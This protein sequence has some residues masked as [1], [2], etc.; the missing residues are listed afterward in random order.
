MRNISRLVL[1]CVVLFATGCLTPIHQ[2]NWIVVNSPNFEIMSTLSTE[3]TMELATDLERFRALIHAVTTTPKKES[4]VPTRIVAFASPSQYIPFAPAR[5]TAGFFN[6]AVRANTVALV[7]QSNV[8]D[9]RTV[10]FHEYVHFILQNG[11]TVTY[12]LWYNEGFAE[13]L[14][15]VRAHKGNLVI[16]ALPRIRISAFTHGN[17]LPM[18]RVLEVTDYSDLTSDQVGMFYAEAWALAH[19]VTLDR[20]VPGSLERYLALREEGIPPQAAY[21]EAF[22]ESIADS[23]NSIRRKLR[24]GDWRLHGIPI[25]KLDYDA[26][27]ATTRRPG[28]DEVATRLGMLHFVAGDW[29]DA[30]KLF[31]SA[32]VVNAENARAIAGMGDTYKF[33]KQFERAE[34]YFRRAVELAPDDPY[35]QLDLAEFLHDYALEQPK[36]QERSRLMREARNAYAKALELDADAPETH[37]MIGRTYLAAGEDPFLAMA[38]IERAYMALPAVQDVTYSLAEAYLANHKE[39]EAQ[40]LLRRALHSQGKG[41]VSSD[42][43]QAIDAIRKHRAE[44]LSKYDG[45]DPEVGGESESGS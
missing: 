10:I 44:E 31:E 19:Y 40:A 16:G 38:P 5:Q 17:W 35:N 1:A 28:E 43:S 37:L 15:T 11:T 8:L 18:R 45:K 27:P 29:D 25:D 12:P 34:P 3:E 2:A 41:S 23:E 42:V 6:D 9:A 7:D 20:N 36:G 22:G 26:T 30:R 14:S 13:V 4:P 21:L 24:K 39:A 33:Q 32:L